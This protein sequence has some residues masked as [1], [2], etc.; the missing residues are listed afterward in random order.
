MSIKVRV[1]FDIEVDSPATI[2]AYGIALGYALRSAAINAVKVADAPG[3]EVSMGK[4][5]LVFEQ[6]NGVA[7]G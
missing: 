5:D 7:R 2:S 4:V 1:S 3:A 6:I